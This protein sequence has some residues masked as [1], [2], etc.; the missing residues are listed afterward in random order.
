MTIRGLVVVVLACVACGE[1]EQ[2]REEAAMR[3]AIPKRLQSDGTIKLYVLDHPADPYDGGVTENHLYS[4]GHI[5]VVAG[6][7]P[8]TM[9]KAKAF[10]V[11]W[12]EGFSAY[13]RTGKFPNKGRRIHV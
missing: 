7:E 2:E 1:S 9:D 10:A 12:M 5:C 4:D 6:Y 13:I 11:H 3:A 8:R